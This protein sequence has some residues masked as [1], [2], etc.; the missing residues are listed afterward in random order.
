MRKALFIVMAIAVLLTSGC[1]ADSEGNYPVTRIGI[2]KD[3]P[4]WELAKA[5]RWQ[6]TKKISRIAEENPELL[7]YQDERYGVTL[8]IWAVGT[9]RYQSAKALL[10]NGADPD[11]IATSYG[12]TAL[13]LA[14]G[15]S[16]VDNMAKK[17]PKYVELLLEYGADPNIVFLGNEK[18]NITE[19]G[20]SPLME[21]I[22]CG[23]GKT[24]ALVEGGADI[25]HKS[26]QGKTAAISALY[27][28]SRGSV[29]LSQYAHYLIAVKKANV[30]D[31][32]KSVY[33]FIP[34]SYSMEYYP[35]ELLREWMPKLDSEEHRMKMEIIDEFARQ[36][37]DYWSTPID[38]HNLKEIKKLYPDSWEEY[39]KRY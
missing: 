9:E 2:F 27:A 25:N 34:E 10:E 11:I 30:V 38:E 21:S 18:N 31:S 19:V 15:F 23:F 29:E 12:Y 4:A 17:D 5:V 35:V 8:L 7:D 33:S 6:N 20:T 32:Y 37:V 1:V 28:A 24:K 26:V 3:S 16:W 13:Y 22:R 14:S 39:A 36:G